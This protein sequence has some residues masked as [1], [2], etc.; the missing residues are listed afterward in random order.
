MVDYTRWTKIRE[1]FPQTPLGISGFLIFILKDHFKR[2]NRYSDTAIESKLVIDLHQQ[3]NPANCENYPGIYVQRGEW[4]VR[5]Q[6]RTIGDIYSYLQEPDGIICH[7]PITATYQIYCV[8]KEYGEVENL[9]LDVWNFFVGFGPVIRESY[10][11]AQFLVTDLSKIELIREEKNYRLGSISLFIN[12][13][14]SW[15]LVT[16]KGLIKDVD[17]TVRS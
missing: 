11:L 17:L 5:Q 1:Q 2:L 4:R 14:Y 8:G 6:D 15:K 16:E 3:W 9:L 13:T 10:Q 7:L 12:F